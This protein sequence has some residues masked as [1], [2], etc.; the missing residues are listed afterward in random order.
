MKN[1][2]HFLFLNRSPS[3]LFFFLKK[4]QAATF[5]P[6]L[7]LAKQTRET[8]QIH[9]SQRNSPHFNRSFYPSIFPI[10][11]GGHN[12][13]FPALTLPVREVAPPHL[14]F[15]SLSC[16]SP[17]TADSSFS[18]P[19]FPLTAPCLAL[20]R[21][22][23]SQS[24]LSLCTQ[25]SLLP[26]PD[27]TPPACNHRKHHLQAFPLCQHSPQKWLSTHPL[28]SLSSVPPDNIQNQ[29]P[30]PSLPFSSLALPPAVIEKHQNRKLAFPRK[31]PAASS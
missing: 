2:N 14:T 7:A 3:S 31:I 21:I 24:K 11:A 13:H 16:P 30:Q 22:S 18:F 25:A 19:R 28:F 29:K 4:K 17:Q 15:P 12:T 8:T 5:T 23:L 6:F 26:S 20:I 27:L 1:L 10:A 9:K